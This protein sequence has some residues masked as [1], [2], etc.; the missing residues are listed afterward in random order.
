MTDCAVET[1]LWVGGVELMSRSFNRLFPFTI[2]PKHS[3]AVEKQVVTMSPT[4]GSVTMYDT[5]YYTRLQGSA[6]VAATDKISLP[7]TGVVTSIT[8]WKK[9][10]EIQ[11]DATVSYQSDG[12]VEYGDYLITALLD[13]PQQ[14]AYF[15]STPDFFDF[16]S[17]VI[18]LRDAEMTGGACSSRMTETVKT[19]TYK[20]IANGA[21]TP[22]NDQFTVTSY[23]VVEPVA[24]IEGVGDSP[25]M[26]T[27]LVGFV[28]VSSRKVQAVPGN[29]AWCP[30][31]GE[32]LHFYERMDACVDPKYPSA[33]LGALYN[34]S[35]RDVTS[36]EN[37]PVPVARQ[38]Y[39]MMNPTPFGI[40]P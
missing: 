15:P 38:A 17:G 5:D 32:L 2:I 40:K 1:S 10:K 7:Y 22:S 28:P 21:Q 16:G 24:I 30:V 25:Q 29:T 8:P 31:R 35:W 20:G 3:S 34:G 39:M 13:C 18:L 9:A 11:G 26:H 4:S 12:Y 36:A 19:Y 27:L 33:L 23:P 14:R 37:E 6:Y